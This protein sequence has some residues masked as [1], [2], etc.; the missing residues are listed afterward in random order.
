MLKF[1]LAKNIKPILIKEDLT[2]WKKDDISKTISKMTEVVEK[3]GSKVLDYLGQKKEEASLAI[4]MRI[5][6]AELD[7]LFSEYGAVMYSIAIGDE[8]CSCET[9]RTLVEEL[10]EQITKTEQEIELLED[11]LLEL[12][13][14]A[15]FA[16]AEE[17]TIPEFVFCSKCG[18]KH[19]YEE[20]FCSRCGTKLNHD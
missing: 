6:D 3:R 2:M 15:E 5:L 13:A 20:S 8:S 1:I 16:T 14:E 18:R 17:E 7:K 12:K 11:E 10:I 4:K 9:R 19:D